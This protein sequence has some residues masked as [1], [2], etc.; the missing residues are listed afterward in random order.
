M[1]SATFLQAGAL[2]LLFV[3]SHPSFAAL[4]GDFASVQADQAHMK[5]TIRSS[6][7]QAYTVHE[8]QSPSHI[9]IREYVS[10]EGKVFGVA[11]NG[12]FR[13]DLR[14]IMGYYFDQYSQAVQAK[15]A[16]Q[17]GHAPVSISQP[18][19]FVQMTGHMRAFSGRAYVPNMLPQGVR[20]EEVR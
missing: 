6:Q 10:P 17:H 16:A 18:G 5:G 7:A 4:G 14:Q 3:F 20:A 8:I 1:K 15:K 2:A 11:W 12:Q 9:L 19:L 13:P